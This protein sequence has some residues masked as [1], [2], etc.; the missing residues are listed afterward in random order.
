MRNEGTL[1]AWVVEIAM[2]LTVFWFFS[3]RSISSYFEH[4]SL[5]FIYQYTA[6]Y[7]AS[8]Q[9]GEVRVSLDEAVGIKQATGWT[10]STR[11]PLFFQTG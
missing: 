7:R 1:G 6:M 5:T 3:F 10:L 9:V 8:T 11:R 2:T 4:I